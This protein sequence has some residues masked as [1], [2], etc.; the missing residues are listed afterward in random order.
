[1]CPPH[2]PRLSQLL[3]QVH[4][5]NDQYHNHSRHH[6][7]EQPDVQFFVRHA[8]A[9]GKEFEQSHAL[10]E[11]FIHGFHCSPLADHFSIRG[12]PTLV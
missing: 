10:V 12:G 3:P 9:R 11:Y 7:H 1:M 4:T 8:K 5:Q 6:D 2:P